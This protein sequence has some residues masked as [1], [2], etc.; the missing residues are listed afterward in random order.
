MHMAQGSA[1]LFIPDFEL[2][3]FVFKSPSAKVHATF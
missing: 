1:T 2:S 3:A